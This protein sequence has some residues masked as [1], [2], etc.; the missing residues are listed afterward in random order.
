MAPTTACS[1]SNRPLNPEC[2]EFHLRSDLAD[3]TPESFSD[4]CGTTSIAATTTTSESNGEAAPEEDCNSLAVTLNNHQHHE[5][6]E[7]ATTRLTDES[8]E[9]ADV[10]S[11]DL[12]N[13]T[14]HKLPNGCDEEEKEEKQE[15][16]EEV[17]KNSRTSNGGITTQPRR[18]YSAKALKFVRE[19]TP[20]PDLDDETN[21]HE[22]A[23]R[24]VAVDELTLVLSTTT[25][26][27]AQASQNDADLGKSHMM[28]VHR[29]VN[30]F[31]S[32]HPPH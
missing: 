19:P 4:S 24:D 16:Q 15:E 32:L 28:F 1:L 23:Q 6:I 26:I 20:G 21:N 25:I 5:D 11:K 31:V 13:G 2:Q 14:D 29:T 12:E 7:E 18:K 17:T 10:D 22:E 30:I 3:S 9:T 8:A 27:E